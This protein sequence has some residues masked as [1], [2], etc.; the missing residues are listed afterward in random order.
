MGLRGRKPRPSLPVDLY[1]CAEAIY[2]EFRFLGEKWPEAGRGDEAGPSQA[3]LNATPLWTI[4]WT[5]KPK[6]P[7]DLAR[8]AGF[9]FPPEQELLWPDQDA[10]PQP[11]FELRADFPNVQYCLEHYTEQLAQAMKYR[12]FPKSSRPGHEFKRLW[13][14]SRAL[15]AAHLKVKLSTAIKLVS[16]DRPEERALRRPRRAR[17][18]RPADSAS[19]SPAPTG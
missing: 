16:S 19:S 15:A 13:F 1:R 17:T 7:T 9:F 3:E 4:L 12:L 10:A 6:S 2:W 5:P 8:V 11:E 14:I 18:V